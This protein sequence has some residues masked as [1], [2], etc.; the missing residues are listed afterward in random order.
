[1]DRDC[2]DI[3]TTKGIGSGIVR[4]RSDCMPA[5]SVKPLYVGVINT[6]F[7]CRGSLA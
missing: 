4:N 3:R 5:G 1:M 6:D 7:Q 2:A